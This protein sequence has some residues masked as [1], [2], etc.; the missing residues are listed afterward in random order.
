MPSKSKSQQRFFGM[1]DAYKKGKLKDPSKKIKDAANGMSRKDVRDFAS[2]KH[3]GLPEKVEVNM[4]RKLIRLT[5]SDLHRMIR[6]TVNRILREDVGYNGI[7]DEWYQEEDYN[8]NVGEKGM[9]RSYEIGMYYDSNA[10]QDAKENGYDNLA[11]YLRYYFDEIRPE[12][13]WYW[14]KIG[15]GYGFNG[16][17]IFSEAVPN[18]GTVVCKNIYGQIVFDEYPTGYAEY[19]QDFNNRLNRGEY[20]TK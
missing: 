12:C 5:E 17:T 1:V 3:K 19:E 10:E 11:D 16:D 8:G 6:S 4:K 13:P 14:T 15:N 20:Y 9:I 18:G 2:T 7:N